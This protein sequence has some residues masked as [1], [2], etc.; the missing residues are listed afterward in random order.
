MDDRVESL[1]SESGAAQGTTGQKVPRQRA[2]DA[3]ILNTLQDLGYEPGNLPN[4]QPGF[5]RVKSAIRK[6]LGHDPLFA[7]TSAFDKAWER[8]R[9]SVAYGTQ[10]PQDPTVLGSQS[11]AAQGT[12]KEREHLGLAQHAAILKTLTELGHPDPKKLPMYSNG[13]PG[14]KSEV[15]ALLNGKEPF[16]SRTAFER[17]WEQAGVKY[18]K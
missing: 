6:V 10:N 14:V 8:M 1:R 3:A 2:Q 9:S 4:V 5:P 11:G 17:A 15:R 7:G 13:K 16:Q 18:V 12:R